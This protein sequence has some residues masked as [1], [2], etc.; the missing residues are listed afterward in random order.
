MADITL[1]VVEG[2]KTEP[3]FLESIKKCFFSD[4][5]IE[6]ITLP[7]EG[8]I[9]QL[10]NEISIDDDLDIF[11]LVKEKFSS[12][13][14]QLEN[15]K[16]RDEISDI[17]FFFDY[18]GHASKANDN[19]IIKMLEL[20]CCET[21]NG[22]LYISYPMVE[23]N[24]HISD[25]EN[26]NR[27]V[28][29][30]ANGCD[31]KQIV[32]DSSSNKYKQVKKFDRTVWLELIEK[33]LAKA[34]YLISGELRFPTPS[35]TFQQLSQQNIF[36]IQSEKYIAQHGLVAILGSFPFFIVEY[37]GD[38]IFKEISSCSEISQVA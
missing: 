19:T 9:Y 29:C 21:D 28:F 16:N 38:C 15:I 17:Y 20:F 30:V 31:Y 35:E 10:F 24:R 27:T 6:F 4:K 5:N 18:D 23:A 8:S 25:N 36:K 1:F 34:C 33:N 11:P 7:N 3:Q 13:I 22:K 12:T 14:P 2:P 32:N 26:F 37:F